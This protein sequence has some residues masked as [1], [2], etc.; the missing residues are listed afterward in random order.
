MARLLPFLLA[1]IA[2]GAPITVAQS[3]EMACVQG[4][5][6]GLEIPSGSQ[7]TFR[8]EIWDPA[9]FPFGIDPLYGYLTLPHDPDNNQGTCVWT[10]NTDFIPECAS[11]PTGGKEAC[12]PPNT[13]Y[14]I[15][16]Q[17]I[18]SNARTTFTYFLC[19]NVP[20]DD[21]EYP[22]YDPQPHGFYCPY[23]GD[24]PNQQHVALKWDGTEVDIQPFNLALPAGVGV[25]DAIA[26]KFGS[27]DEHWVLPYDYNAVCAYLADDGNPTND[28]PS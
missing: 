3:L 6:L 15:D 11:F 10:A 16:I 23:G 19:S 9:D 21:D 28:C 13:A 7:D 14:V 27:N 26:A 22:E 4:H 18:Q 8:I 1:L 24:A 5:E 25:S 12:L 2:L 20:P 17:H